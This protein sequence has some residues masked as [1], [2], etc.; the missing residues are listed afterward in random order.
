MEKEAYTKDNLEELKKQYRKIYQQL[1]KDILQEDYKLLLLLSEDKI[2]EPIKAL[3]RREK[4]IR[5]CDWGRQV[6]IDSNEDVWPCLYFSEN[7]KY[8]MSNINKKKSKSFLLK[9]PKNSYSKNCFECSVSTLC[10]GYCKY[11]AIM[12]N[13]NIN[14]KSEFECALRRLYAEE[15]LKLIIDLYKAKY[16]LKK[17]YYEFLDK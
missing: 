13:E 5:R 11:T 4:I 14:I 1:Y 16:D 12:E 8:K 2:T 9:I 6:I 7:K 17:L 15:S 3:L 10:G